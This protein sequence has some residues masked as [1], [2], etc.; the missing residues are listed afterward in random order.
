VEVEEDTL[1]I[2]PNGI[3]SAEEAEADS[4]ELIPPTAADE[5]EG[6]GAPPPLTEPQH[7]E[8]PDSP[9]EPE[10][11]VAPEGPDEVIE[12]DEPAAGPVETADTAEPV[13]NPAADTAEEVPQPTNQ[14]PEGAEE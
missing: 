9:A 2:G 14:A 7:G 12:P 6:G 5:Q 1:V 3:E 4:T 11:P 10:E 13:G 8:E